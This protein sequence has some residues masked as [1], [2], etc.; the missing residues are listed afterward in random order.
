MKLLN[1]AIGDTHKTTSGFSFSAQALDSLG[2]SEYTLANLAIDVSSSTDAFIDDTRKMVAAVVET[3]KS[4][5]NPRVENLLLRVETFNSSLNEIHGFTEL[6]NV[7]AA[8]YQLVASGM[9]ALY[10]AAGSGLE[11]IGKYAEELEKFDYI[12]NGIQFIITDGM[13]NQSHKLRTPASIKSAADA[14]MRQEKLESLKTIVIGIGSEYEV[15]GYLDSFSKEIGADQFVWV[16][17]ATPTALAKVA[18]FISK[19]IS[20]QSQSLGSGGASQNI[21][22]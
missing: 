6:K 9:T 1:V 8:A 18:G 7:D 22:F 11:A 3:L 10:D 5:S 4:P 12:A 2:S 14:I 19:S 20:S 21:N 17:D 15:R 13:E 16:G